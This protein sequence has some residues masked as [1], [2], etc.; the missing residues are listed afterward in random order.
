MTLPALE[1]TDY[2]DVNYTH[3]VHVLRGAFTAECLP[4]GTGVCFGVGND[5][6]SLASFSADL[7][8]PNAIVFSVEPGITDRS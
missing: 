4:G 8:N 6:T 7:T 5:V 1:G 3:T 2:N